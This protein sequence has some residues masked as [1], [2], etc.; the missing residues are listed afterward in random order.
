MRPRI[1]TPC[2]ITACGL[3]ALFATA[4]WLLFHLTGCAPMPRYSWD[5]DGWADKRTG[6]D[7][8]R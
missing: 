1:S 5:A 3:L 6:L 2:L 4:A 7:V 8:K